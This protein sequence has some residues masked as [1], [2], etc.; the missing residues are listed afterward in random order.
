MNRSSQGSAVFMRPFQHRK[1]R[2]SMIK[3]LS[4]LSDLHGRFSDDADQ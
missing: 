1:Q 3:A 4:E 2:R